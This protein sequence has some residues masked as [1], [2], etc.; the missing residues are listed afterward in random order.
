[1]SASVVIDPSQTHETGELKHQNPL[2]TLR[3]DPTGRYVAAGAQDLDV[4][5]WNLEDGNH[6]SL[7]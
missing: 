4:Q 7:A 3:V 5:L 2:T 6:F 1:M